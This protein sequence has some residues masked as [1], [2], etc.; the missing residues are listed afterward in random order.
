MNKIFLITVAIGIIATVNPASAVTKCVRLS[1]V[2]SCT[3]LPTTYKN[4]AYWNATCGGVSVQGVAVCS[5]TASTTIGS[6]STAPYVSST[7]SS[8][9]Y[10]K[11][12]MVSPAVSRWIVPGTCTDSMCIEP[13][14]MTAAECAEYCG[15]MC[16]SAIAG[17]YGNDG[18]NENTTT[19]RSAMFSNLSD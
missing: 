5:S 6:S 8:N 7:T 16:A 11:C 3:T 4:R 18:V 14:L 17:M 19:F 1:A 15:L 10:C 13:S 9:K 12:K 2:T